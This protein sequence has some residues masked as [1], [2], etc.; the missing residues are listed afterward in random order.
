MAFRW[1]W[2]E[3]ERQ[4]RFAVLELGVDRFGEMRRL[5]QLFPPSIA[6]VT[7]VAPAHLRFLG[8]EEHIA[9]EKAELVRALAEGGLALLNGDDPRVAAMA[10]HA[11]R[12]ALFGVHA[13]HLALRAADVRAGVD[14]TRFTVVLEDA[15][16][17]ARDS[18]STKIPAFISLLGEHSVYT[19]L[20]AIGVALRCGLDIQQAIERLGL[21]ERQ[22]GR[23]MPLPGA[24]GS[25]LLD[26]TYNASPASA[27]AALRTLAALPAR[28]RIAVFGDMLELGDRA[29]RLHRQLGA[30]VA[31]VADLLVTKGDLAGLL[32]PSPLVG[33]GLGVRG[34]VTYTAADAVAALH[35]LL[36]P[37]DVVLIKGSAETRMEQVTAGL[38]APHVDAAAV[39]VRQE[40]AFAVRAGAPDRPTWLEVDLLA[41]AENTHALARIVGPDVRILAT[42]KA[43]AY[44]HG[45]L[46]VARAVL[47]HGAWGLAVAT[48]GEALALRDAGIA[49]PI[50]ILGYTPP[51]QVRDAIRRDVR[52]TVFDSNTARE[53]GAAA[54]ELQRNATIHVKVDTGMA[55]LGTQPEGA[56]PLLRQLSE[57]DG[58]EVE[59][60]F[61]HLASADSAD[62]GFAREQLARWETV[63][64]AAAA[65]GL[66]PPL[67]H[68]ANSAAL[69]RFPEARY[70]LV[71]PGAAIYGL[72][73][74]LETPL[75][76]S[77]Q[78]AL[79]FK[80]EIAQV[81]YWPVGAPVSYGG[82]WIAGRPSRIA[83][84]PVGYAD[85][86]RRSPS[87]RYVLV[88]GQRAPVIGRVAMDYAMLDVTE[89]SDARA[90][91][92]VVLI[93]VQG[94]ECITAD[95]VAGWLGTINYEV[96]SGILPRVPRVV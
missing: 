25:L 73:P 23:L 33:E 42:L 85:G 6:V 55:R 41:I 43:D 40:R 37:G 71:R 44:G 29:P 28:R 56:L 30:H 72:S 91:D 1:P 62:E 8:D 10:A 12:V 7:N 3:L 78:P 67:A 75:P 82:T 54:H 93:G 26:D 68:V 92:E 24:N 17:F 88:R 20:A 53:I 81:K 34:I 39:L 35:P 64:R 77:F 65:E 61:T 90:G 94:G 69:L 16:A 48:L 19:A 45:A 76:S 49:A 58:V 5:A 14:G 32:A 27:H 57:L 95:D 31:G 15:V 84:I 59:G 38:L 21:V 11:P 63:L 2:V 50:L 18:P 80:T 96:V 47:Q 46:R 70:D 60:I 13:A 86:F 66:R 22:A 74:S 79:S 36:E 9:A 89:I 87:W 51:W 4:H 83:T 52:L